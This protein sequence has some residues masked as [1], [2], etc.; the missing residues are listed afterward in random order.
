MGGNMPPHS[1]EVQLTELE[2]DIMQTFTKRKIL[3]DQEAMDALLTLYSK[4]AG[5]YAKNHSI[6]DKEDRI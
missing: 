2:I 5:N 1:K 3:T 6:R 4:L